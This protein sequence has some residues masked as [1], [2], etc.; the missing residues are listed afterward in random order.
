MI[1]SNVRVCVRVSGEYVLCNVCRRMC[2]RVC[3]GC[4]CEVCMQ[5]RAHIRIRLRI[6]VFARVYSVCELG[7]C[8]LRGRCRLAQH[9]RKCLCACV[10]LRFCFFLEVGRRPASAWRNGVCEDDRRFVMVYPNSDV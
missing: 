3:C 2:V 7:V 1:L 8:A 10:L 4:A 5:V 6:C 9:N